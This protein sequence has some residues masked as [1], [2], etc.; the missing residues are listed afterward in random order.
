MAKRGTKAW[1]MN[2]SASR[3]GDRY[4]ENIDL[5]CPWCRGKGQIE[6]PGYIFRWRREMAGQTQGEF[7]AN[8]A[9]GRTT[10]QEVERGIRKPPSFL[11]DEYNALPKFYKFITDDRTRENYHPKLTIINN[12]G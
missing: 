3:G 10:I 11:V 12:K 5:P 7:V 8:S 1:K 4:W 6:N 2:I 9:Y